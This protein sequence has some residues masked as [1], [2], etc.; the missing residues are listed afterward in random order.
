MELFVSFEVTPLLIGHCLGGKAGG[1]TFAL[2]NHWVFTL[3]FGAQDG[4][5]HDSTPETTILLCKRV[6]FKLNLI[7]NSHLLQKHL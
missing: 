7:F 3:G 5:A 4:V 2:G 6:C 1:A